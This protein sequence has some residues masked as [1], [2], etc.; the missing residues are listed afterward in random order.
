ML[1]TTK[2]STI[3][4]QQQG[5]W[6]TLVRMKREEGWRQGFFKGNGTNVFVRVIFQKTT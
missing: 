3:I 5:I 1:E 6:K 2:E 4:H